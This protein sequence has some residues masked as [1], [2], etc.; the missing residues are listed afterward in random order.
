MREIS[1]IVVHATGGWKTQTLTSIM[2]GWRAM[3]WRNPGYHWIIDADGRRKQLLPEAQIANGV[4]G[5]NAHSVHVA[6][7][8]GLVS[9]GVYGDTRTPLQRRT[10]LITLKELRRRYPSAEILGHRDLSP[11][12]NGD[13]IISPWEFIKVCPCFDAREE[14]KNLT[15][16]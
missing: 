6:Y 3:G 4:R 1:Y 9:K 14:Y 2:E 7:V 16:A 12:K 8:G 5:H 13:G 10:L 11:D 15:L